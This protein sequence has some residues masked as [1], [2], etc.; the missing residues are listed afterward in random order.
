MPRAGKRDGK[1][2]YARA[3]ARGYRFRP[4]IAIS[5][6]FAARLDAYCAVTGDKPGTVIEAVLRCVLG[7]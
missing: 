6:S 4:T 5:R 3:K 2:E 7:A 1:A